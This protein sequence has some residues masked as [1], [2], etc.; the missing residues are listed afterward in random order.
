M[1]FFV[2]LVLL[3]I[4]STV[5]N[6]VFMKKQKSEEK[7][8]NKKKYV[9]IRK[10]LLG[11][12][13]VT[14]AFLV[15]LIAVVCGIQFSNGNSHEAIEKERIYLTY[16]VE[17]NEYYNTDVVSRIDKFNRIIESS[18]KYIKNP[19]VGIFYTKTHAE[20]EPIVYQIIIPKTENK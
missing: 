9:K 18:K 16:K 7:S 11:V 15:V 13:A 14:F 19:W 3:L 1:L 2:I 10:G 5:L 20:T 4:G 6:A 8:E 12:S 17:N